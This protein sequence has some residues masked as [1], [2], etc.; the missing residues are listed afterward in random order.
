[1]KDIFATCLFCDDIRREDN[2]KEMLVGI[3]THG[4]TVPELPFVQPRFWFQA[5]LY[6]PIEDPVGLKLIRIIYPDGET[7]DTEINAPAA[8]PIEAVEDGP[9]YLRVRGNLQLMPLKISQEGRIQVWV[10]TDEDEKVYAG[11]L[12]VSLGKRGQIDRSNSL[13]SIS[14]MSALYQEISGKLGRSRGGLAVKMLGSIERILG[15]LELPKE[16]SELVVVPLNETEADVYYRTS[17]KKSPSVSLES[18]PPGAKIKTT[19]RDRFGFRI[20]RADPEGESYSVAINIDDQ[21]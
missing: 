21:E 12:M 14:T 10:I 17:R 19:N 15:P 1:M 11:S 4:M 6:S 2:G 8:K 16:D 9:K 18:K 20:I 7:L 13:A 3:Y 5:C